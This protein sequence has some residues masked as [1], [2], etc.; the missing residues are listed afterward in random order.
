MK[1]ECDSIPRISYLMRVNFSVDWFKLCMP[2]VFDVG[3]TVVYY[4]D[5][6]IYDLTIYFSCISQ[7]RTLS[8]LEVKSKSKTNID[9]RLQ[10]K[11]RKAKKYKRKKYKVLF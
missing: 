11:S 10:V 3:Y 6:Y 5:V 2:F 9:I 7:N 8:T 4:I 1:D